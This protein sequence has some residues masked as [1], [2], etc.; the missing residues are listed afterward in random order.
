MPRYNFDEYI[1]S[2]IQSEDKDKESVADESLTTELFLYNEEKG[3]I[4]AATMNIYQH[5]D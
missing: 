3:R 5:Q 4:W 2:C 1:K